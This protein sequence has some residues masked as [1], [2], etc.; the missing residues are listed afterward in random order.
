MARFGRSNCSINA[1]RHE[2]TTRSEATNNLS[3]L[4]CAVAKLVAN[5]TYHGFSSNRSCSGKVF[6]L[7]PKKKEGWE[8]E[9]SMST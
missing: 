8:L 1:A 9:R 5:L 7:G 4:Q 6:A 2:M 3:F